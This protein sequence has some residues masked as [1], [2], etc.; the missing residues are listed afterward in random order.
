MLVAAPENGRGTNR[1][2]ANRGRIQ[3]LTRFSGIVRN[4]G[5]LLLRP[6]GGVVTQRTANPVPQ[7]R[8]RDSWHNSPSVPCI[9]FQ[10]LSIW[11]ANCCLIAAFPI[12]RT[13]PPCFCHV[14]GCTG[15]AKMAV[16]DGA[17]SSELKAPFRLQSMSPVVWEQRRIAYR[18]GTYKPWALTTPFA[19]TDKRERRARDGVRR[20]ETR[21]RLGCLSTAKPGP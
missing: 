8:F 21:K 13:E 3:V 12:G 5:N 11:S 20:T 2:T 9:A 6:D 7:A 4:G 19:G 18:T 14:G 10:G 15:G 17:A 1:E 16:G